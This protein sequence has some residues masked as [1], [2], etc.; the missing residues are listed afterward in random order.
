V[1]RGSTR[2]E[3][4]LSGGFGVVVAVDHSHVFAHAVAMVVP[5]N[6]ADEER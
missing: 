2:L 6:I 1:Q 3:P 4:T 5:V